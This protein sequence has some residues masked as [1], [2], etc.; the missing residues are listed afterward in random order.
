M[1]NFEAKKPITGGFIGG[2]VKVRFNPVF[3]PSFRTMGPVWALILDWTTVS[4]PVLIRTSF[5]RRGVNFD[6]TVRFHIYA[7]IYQCRTMPVCSSRLGGESAVH[8][9]RDLPNTEW[10]TCLVRAFRFCSLV[11]P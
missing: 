11:P 8:A 6:T 4:G 5:T 2:G 3:G 10:P 9:S 7:S 1:S